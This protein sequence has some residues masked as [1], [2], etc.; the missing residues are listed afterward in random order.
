MMA[1]VCS[2]SPC[3][4]YLLMIGSRGGRMMARI[5]DGDELR[6]YAINSDGIVALPR[7]W[8]RLIHEGNWA[9]MIASPLN[10]VTSVV[11]LG[12]LSTGVLLWARRRFR[13]PGEAAKAAIGRSPALGSTA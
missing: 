11:L 3:T 7:N 2:T 5:Y 6:A 1:T 4:I 12:L 13:R 9:A 8:P 10:V